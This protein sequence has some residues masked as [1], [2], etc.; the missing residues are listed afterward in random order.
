M[1][2][3]FYFFFFFFGEMGFYFYL[4]LYV[5]GLFIFGVSC[6]Y[7]YV[8]FS[9]VQWSTA[10]FLGFPFSP[11]SICSFIKINKKA[12]LL[13][14]MLHWRLITTRIFPLYYEYASLLCVPA[15][16]S[17][18]YTLRIQ[19]NMYEHNWVRSPMYVCLVFGVTSQINI[20]MALARLHILYSKTDTQVTFFFLEVIDTQVTFFFLIIW[21]TSNLDSCKYNSHDELHFCLHF[22]VHVMKLPSC[23]TKELLDLNIQ[24]AN[25]P[26]ISIQCLQIHDY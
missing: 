22:C 20:N 23:L 17:K 9:C 19:T 8:T 3:Y 14:S 13:L 11:K 1:G 2:F 10:L 15:V 4:I 21:H 7:A 26:H 6:W 12:S 24:L 18:R 16:W 5:F 25:K